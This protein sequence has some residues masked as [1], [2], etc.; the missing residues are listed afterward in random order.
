MLLPDVFRLIETADRHGC[1]RMVETVKRLTHR[2]GS[3]S[4]STLGLP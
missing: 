2:R 4:F 3:S 1:V